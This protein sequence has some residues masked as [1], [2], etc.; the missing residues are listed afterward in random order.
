[1]LYVL[2]SDFLFDVF[3]KISVT[4]TDLSDTYKI[5]EFIKETLLRKI[6]VSSM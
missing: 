6:L 2:N 4:V 3:C 5:K 1:M